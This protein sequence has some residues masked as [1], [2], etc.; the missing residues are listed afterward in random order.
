[1]SDYDEAS[2]AQQAR[3]AFI[4]ENTGLFNDGSKSYQVL[5]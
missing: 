4:G 5:F 1:M 2:T 3:Y